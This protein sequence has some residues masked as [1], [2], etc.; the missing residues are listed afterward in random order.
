[1]ATTRCFFDPK[2][3]AGALA[4]KLIG[5]EARSSVR[6]IRA[7]TCYNC[8]EIVVAEGPY[9]VLVG[10][11][12]TERK[13]RLEALY[14]QARD[15]Y[16][17]GQPIIVDDMFDKVELKLRWY[18]SK[19]VVKYPRCS[20][21]RHSAYADAEEDPPQSAALASIW[22]LILTFGGS[23][24]LLPILYSVE[25]AYQIAFDLGHSHGDQAPG[26][27]FLSMVNGVLFIILGC[28]IGY[29]IASA[30]IG[31]LQ[32][33]WRKDLVALRGACPNCGEQVFAFLRSDQ[34]NSNSHRASCHVCDCSLE[35]RTKIEP[36]ATSGRRW[37]YGRI[38]L[39]QE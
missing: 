5:S 33:L 8:D 30:S 34:S 22:M 3:I 15:A 21:R 24:C 2:L 6:R 16:Y 9:C 13:E 7:A 19:S 26:M 18:G 32:E 23:A 38:Y 25:L 39:V 29:P 20:I 36:K 28:V 31:V 10:P 37:V 4:G 11:I 14:C 17:S 35:F 1:M 12:E 27:G